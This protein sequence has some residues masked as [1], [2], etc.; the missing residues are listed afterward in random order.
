LRIQKQAG[1]NDIPIIF[2]LTNPDGTKESFSK[3]MDGDIIFK[4][5]SNIK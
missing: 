4:Q 1:L 2:N 3:T 5:Q